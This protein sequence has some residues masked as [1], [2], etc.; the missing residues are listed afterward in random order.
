MTPDQWYWE[1]I[2]SINQ[3]HLH[4]PGYQPEVSFKVGLHQGDMLAAFHKSTTMPQGVKEILAKMLLY[5]NLYA[6]LD[7]GI[8]TV[9]ISSSEV[10]K[11][12]VS[13]ARL[14]DHLERIQL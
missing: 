13:V 4:T 10:E 14:R 3:W 12:A 11:A 8:T 9:L 6:E 7:K 1:Y 5:L 2:P